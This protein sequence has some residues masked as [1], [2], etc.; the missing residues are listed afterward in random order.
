MF[1]NR[2]RT[3]SIYKTIIH[4]KYY[5]FFH[6]LIQKLKNVK[7][8]NPENVVFKRM[9]TNILDFQLECSHGVHTEEVEQIPH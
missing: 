3:Y 9:R 4:R 6:L 8:Q 2:I 5:L 7:I 1:Q